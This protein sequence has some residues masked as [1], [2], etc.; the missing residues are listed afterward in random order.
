MTAHAPTKYSLPHPVDVAAIERELVELWRDPDRDPTTQQ[1]ITRA[2]MSNLLIYAPTVEAA[3][4]IPDE[5]GIIVRHHPARVLLL[6]G[7]S[8]TGGAAV[9]AN[10]SAY[11]SLLGGDRQVCSEYIT[12]TAAGHATERLPSVARSLLIGDLPTS[13][14]WA[15]P[16][17][18]PQ[19]GA[20]FQELARMSGQII[21]ESQGWLDPVRGVIAAADW[22]ASEETSQ[23]LADLEWRRLKT[24]RRLISQTLDPTVLPGALESIT[25][26]RFEHGPHAL[27]KTWMLVGWLACKL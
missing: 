8:N 3:Q 15:V 17:P 7:E 21:Y 11:C 23:V 6:V 27:A 19:G 25:E 9:Q 18:P 22:A 14:W 24:W 4:D 16:Q 13:L 10:V 12:I 26:V 5:I 2:C 20:L 1:S